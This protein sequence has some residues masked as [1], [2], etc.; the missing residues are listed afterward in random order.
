M[1]T[2][3]SVLCV[4]CMLLPG[5]MM[6]LQVHN[7]IQTF[8][9]LSYTELLCKM[10]HKFSWVG[11]LIKGNS[12]AFKICCHTVHLYNVQDTVQVYVHV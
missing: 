12:M 9:T 10:F 8:R 6:H 1:R 7:N 2:M 11:I 4:L 3:R 5:K